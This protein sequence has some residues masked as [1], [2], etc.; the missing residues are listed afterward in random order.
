[1]FSLVKTAVGGLA[2]ACRANGHQQAPLQSYLKV[3][4]AGIKISSVPPDFTG[5]VLPEKPKLKIMNKVPNL[6]KAKKEPKKLRDIQGPTKTGTSFTTGLYGI[7]AMGGGYLH[8][9]HFEMIRLTINR[10]IDE[11]TMF[12]L[13][14][15]SAPYKPITRKSLGHRMGG[16]KGPID[17][18]VTPVKCGRLIVEVGGRVELGEVEHFLTQVAKKLPFPAQV[19]SKESLA[20]MQREQQ[21]REQ[22]N[23]NPWTYK[24][25]VQGNMLGIRNLV[26]PKDLHF[27]G[28]YTGKF[29]Y[30]ERV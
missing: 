23:Q 2:G 27:Q 20:E 1:M 16:G 9:G 8:W 18:Y 10:N 22:N 26:S 29:F 4:T 24:R 5:V 21:E 17:R 15:V 25:I 19:V 7:L 3:L 14:R 28:R 6:I 30:P 13:W 11:K 12:A